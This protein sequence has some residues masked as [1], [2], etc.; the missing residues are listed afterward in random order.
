VVGVD[1]ARGGRDQTLLS[2]RRGLYFDEL[3]AHPG[4]FTPDGP[5]VAGLAVTAATE[6]EHKACVNI[7]VCGV[8]AS[9]YDFLRQIM[10]ERARAVNFGEGS[11][12]RDKSGQLSFHNLRAEAYW[13]LREA[14][15][16]VNGEGLMLP[17]DTALLADLCAPRWSLTSR[18]ILIESK[19]DVIK[20]LGRSPDRADAVV[21]AHFRP[22]L[23]DIGV[24]FM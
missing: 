3:Q 12:E 24:M 16:P 22:K 1:V 23:Y 11:T 8:G 17:D 7:D 6:G 13:R 10:G 20:R 4:T 14:L 21:L 18:G 9:P 2:R 19:D 5:A 15:D